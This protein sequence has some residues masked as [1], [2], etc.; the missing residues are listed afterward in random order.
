MIYC[1]YHA[2]C[3]DGFGAAWVLR[4]VHN[5]TY[6]IG[7]RYNEPLPDLLEGSTVYIVDFS[8]PPEILTELANRMEKVVVIDHHATAVRTLAAY[9]HPSVELVLDLD[10]SGALLTWDYFYP[11]DSPPT[12]LL[13]IEDRDLWRF[14][15]GQTKELTSALL[16]YPMEFDVWDMLMDI[17]VKDLVAE[18]K[19]IERYRSKEIEKYVKAASTTKLSGY[20]VPIVNV[21]YSYVSEVGN[22]LSA[23]QLFAICWSVVEQS[24]MFSLRSNDEGLDVSKI[25]EQY[26][27]GGHRNAAGFKR[28]FTF[29]HSLL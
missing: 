11:S 9:T 25:A 16:S 23:G 13:S 21:P 8:Y 24:V 10:H 28:G 19:A 17:S 27:G 5:E 6:F 14:K 26:N 3:L 12:L 22:I 7:V 4:T 29:L 1:L 20:T 15:R 2:D 18:G